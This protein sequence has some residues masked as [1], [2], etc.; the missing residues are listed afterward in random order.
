[1]ITEVYVMTTVKDGV[2]LVVAWGD[3]K[4]IVTD[5]G[6]V[7][8]FK[9]V[10]RSIIARHSGMEFKILKFSKPIEIPLEVE[11]EQRSHSV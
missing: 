5:D 2:E 8:E 6:K 11:N 7:E 3:C 9:E 1:M 4:M 10:A